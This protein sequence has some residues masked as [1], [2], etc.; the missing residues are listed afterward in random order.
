VPDHPASPVDRRLGRY[1]VGARF[2]DLL[3]LERPVYRPGRLLG[4]QL[5]GLQPGDRVLDLGCGTG[6]NLP[7]LR[8]AVGE[9][10]RV[11]GLDLSPQMLAR[12]RHRVR[13]AGWGNVHLHQ[14][15]AAAVPLDQLLPGQFDAVLMTYTMSIIEDYRKAWERCVAALAPAGRIALVDLGLPRG[16]WAPLRP[17]ANLACRIGGADPTRAP[18]E[19]QS[20]HLR[21]VEHAILLGGHVHIAGWAERRSPR[22]GQ[23]P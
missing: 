23:N 15:D 11:V 20:Q 4:V 13:S 1:A 6:L 12:A 10:G 17:L 16:R 21:Q 5:L 19:L 8:A 9:Q 22:P 2:Y 18:W 7:L 3:S 14:G